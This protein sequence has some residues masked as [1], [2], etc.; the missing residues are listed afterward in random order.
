M[1][2]QI[3]VLS[4]IVSV[5]LARF[6][7]PTPVVCDPSLESDVFLAAAH[8]R[9]STECEAACEVGH[10]YNPC[11]FFTWV[12]NT[13]AGVVNCYQVM[14]IMMTSTDDLRLQNFSQSAVENLKIFV[15]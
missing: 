5:S 10:P 14:M 4:S 7:C 13:A 2:T 9:D 6:K 3:L 1:K 12:P 11:K 8:Y 15:D